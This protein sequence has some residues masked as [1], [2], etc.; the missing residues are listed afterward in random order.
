MLI[1]IV[2]HLDSTSNSPMMHLQQPNRQRQP[3]AAAQRI[4]V[5]SS[6]L[7]IGRGSLRL[8]ITS[9]QIRKQ[10]RSRLQLVG[11]HNP[12]AVR[13]VDHQLR[14][15]LFLEIYHPLRHPLSLLE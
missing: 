10:E 1:T 3:S 5:R 6:R 9:S 7:K 15:D 2:V 8:E 13:E 14:F 12:V 11:V 4:S